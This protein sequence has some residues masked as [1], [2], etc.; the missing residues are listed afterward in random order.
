MIAIQEVEKSPIFGMKGEKEMRKKD[1][2][3]EA[4][5]QSKGALCLQDYAGY[6]EQQLKNLI[7]EQGILNRKMFWI[8]WR[9]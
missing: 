3:T 9:R 2:N 5:L 1:G 7:K 6:S 8:Y 4:L